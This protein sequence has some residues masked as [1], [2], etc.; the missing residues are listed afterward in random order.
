MQGQTPLH[1][2]HNATVHVRPEGIKGACLLHPAVL[3]RCTRHTNPSL[4]LGCP[5]G[6]HSW[7]RM[8]LKANLASVHALPSIEL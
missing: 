1:L 7:A 4:V 6:K 3:R 5:G 8:S 2:P